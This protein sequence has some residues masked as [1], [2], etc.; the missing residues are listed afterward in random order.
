MSNY[1]LPFRKERALKRIY[2]LMDKKRKQVLLRSY[3]EPYQLVSGDL[4]MSRAKNN[5]IFRVEKV[6]DKT[7]IISEGRRKQDEIVLEYGYNLKRI[8]HSNFVIDYLPISV[9]QNDINRSDVLRK[10]LYFIQNFCRK[11]GNGVL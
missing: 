8:R 3:V 9:N 7:I 2:D 6:T 10:R 11:Q 4:F 5:Y 1:W